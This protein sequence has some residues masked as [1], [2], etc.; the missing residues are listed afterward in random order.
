[1]TA[2]IL[3]LALCTQ[4]T[5]QSQFTKVPAISKCLHFIW[6][7]MMTSSVRRENLDSNIGNKTS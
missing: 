3:C 5:R 7:S 6:Q 1:M 2:L 4:K